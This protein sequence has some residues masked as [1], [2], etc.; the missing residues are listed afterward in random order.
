M[1][2]L[3]QGCQATVVAVVRRRVERRVG[4]RCAER[5]GRWRRTT[6]PAAAAEMAGSRGLVVVVR[7]RRRAARSGACPRNEPVSRKLAEFTSG[8]DLLP[9]SPATPDKGVVELVDQ[10]HLADAELVHAVEWRTPRRPRPPWR[11]PPRSRPDG[12]RRALGHGLPPGRRRPAQ[13]PSPAQVTGGRGPAQAPGQQ[14]CGAAYGVGVR[15]GRGLAHLH[16][17]RDAGHRE[18]GVV[19]HRRRDAGEARA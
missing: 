16:R 3:A 5:P 15:L 10:L 13:R 14:G 2:V 8:A 6:R 7:R 11:P 9:L 17:D 12:G 19:E 18:P 1:G 4:D